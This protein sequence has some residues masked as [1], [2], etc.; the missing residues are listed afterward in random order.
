MTDPRTETI[1]FRCTTAERI[2]YETAAKG[3]TLSDW[4]RSLADAALP[5]AEVR[6]EIIVTPPELKPPT[7]SDYRRVP[8]APP[9]PPLRP[10]TQAPERSFRGPFPKSGK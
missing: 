2:A 8:T 1:R 4:L 9:P 10:R 7:V 3:R 6:D 5:G